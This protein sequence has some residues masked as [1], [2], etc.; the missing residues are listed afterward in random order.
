MKE[1]AYRLDLLLASSPEALWPFVSDTDR[2][3]SDAGVPAVER[4]ETGENAR[5]R[6][7][8]SRLGVPIEWEEEPFEWVRPHRFSVS[9]RYARGPIEW[10]QTRVRLEA[11][12]GGGTRLGYE[13]RVRPRNLLGRIAAAFEVGFIRRRRFESVLRGYDAEAALGQRRPA[14]RVRLADGGRERLLAARDALLAAGAEAKLVSLLCEIVEHGDDR[15][16][17]RLRPYVLAAAWDVD[18][19]ETLIVCLQAIR[20]GLL[21]L[22]WDL[23]C[24]R[25]RGSAV[26]DTALDAVG[27]TLH[28]ETCRIDFCSDF[29]RS[30]EV[31][32]APNPGIRFV[33]RV[34]FCVGGPQLTPHIV[35]QQLIGPGERRSMYLQLECGRHRLRTLSGDADV[36][37]VS[38]IGGAATAAVRY[39]SERWSA[40]E[41]RVGQTA[42]LELT[43]AAQDE[44]LFIVERTEWADDAAT[45]AEVTTLQ[46]YRDLFASEALRAD[47]PISVGTVTVVFTD[48]RDS[49]RFYREVGDAP[50][51]GSVLDHIDVLRGAVAAEGGAVVKQMGD[52]IMAV[53]VRPICALR[54]M[55]K[56]HQN[57][58][59]R[60]LPLKVGVHA[61]PCIAVNQNG[62][63]DYFGS[64]VNLAARLVAM[65]TG[66]DL[67]V[68]DVILNDPEVKPLAL[69][70][71]RV[72]QVP[73]GFEEEVLSL[74]RIAAV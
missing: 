46:V 33:P 66:G 29:E 72:E 9:R 61:G 53:F 26:E 28:C 16:V 21:A 65:S 41:A 8:L 69:A 57:L 48:L 55:T 30:V 32:F 49:T 47:E 44:E 64:T 70:A 58:G 73:K 1:V 52:A 71:E 50:A 15:S 17:E 62:V 3:N 36:A 20:S 27:R 11:L 4:L 63:F 54:A 12:A 13:V 51:F 34:E 10:L 2:F 6:L 23:L 39:D 59:G 45:A 67:V 43:N 74:W 42:V 68:S 22:R 7:R 18:R 60:P 24:P 19:R 40:R 31:T 25:C 38:E 35:A 5:R 56:A 37:L 14:A